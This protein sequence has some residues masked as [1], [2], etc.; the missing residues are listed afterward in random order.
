MSSLVAARLGGAVRTTSP[1]CASRRLISLIEADSS[2]AAAAAVSTLD[3]ASLEP[4]TA[5]SARCK[6]WSDVA[7]R[8]LAACFIAVALPTTAMT[9][10]TR[11]RNERYR[12]DHDAP[13]LAPRSV[14]RSCS[15]TS[16]SVTSVCVSTQPPPRSG[17]LI[18]ET[19]RPF[20]ISNGLRVGRALAPLYDAFAGIAFGIAG[21][22]AGLG[23]ARQQFAHRHAAAQLLAPQIVHFDEAH[24]AQDEPAGGV[25]HA[26]RLRHVVE[27]DPRQEIAPTLL[28]DSKQRG[29][30]HKASASTSERPTP[31]A[32]GT[33][34]SAWKIRR[35]RRG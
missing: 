23:A 29:A 24:V 6:V 18:N 26:Q 28:R 34:L 27:R 16:C 11:P 35:G 33:V 4:C 19:I 25:V 20:V 22:G 21:E 14:S 15:A 8:V 5:P 31:A 17:R 30:R 10:S 13:L 7:S 3:E 9:F 12:V 1:V 2:S 32:I